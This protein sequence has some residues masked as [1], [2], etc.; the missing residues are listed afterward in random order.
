VTTRNGDTVYSHLEARVAELE[1]ALALLTRRIERDLIKRVVRVEH[2]VDTILHYL[3]A[4]AD[5]TP[6]PT[7][8]G[9]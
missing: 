4:G 6:A 9:D 3:E 1:R 8:K 2:D 7:P 5:A